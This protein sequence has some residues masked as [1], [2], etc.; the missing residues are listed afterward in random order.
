M[1]SDAPRA[2]EF[3]DWAESVL[4]PV[5]TQGYYLPAEAEPKLLARFDQRIVLRHHVRP[6]RRR[7]D[8]DDC[9]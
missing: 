3:R 7:E 1:L 4:Y 6:L 8:R 2:K 5:M 9:C